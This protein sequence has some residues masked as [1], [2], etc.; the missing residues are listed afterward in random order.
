MG[1]NGQSLPLSPANLVRG[2]RFDVV[3]REYKHSIFTSTLFP[4]SIKLP[5]CWFHQ[6][7]C[8]RRSD[9]GLLAGVLSWVGQD[10]SE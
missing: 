6:P 3:S 7:I 4:P 2:R 8:V 10:V 1:D 9:F 5:I